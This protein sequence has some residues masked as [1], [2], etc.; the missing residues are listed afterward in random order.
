MLQNLTIA[1]GASLS[2]AYDVGGSSG[3]V[4]GLIFDALFGGLGACSFQVSADGVAWVDLYDFAG[5][6][7]VWNVVPGTAM[8][9]EQD[10]HQILARWRYI[11]IRAGIAAFPVLQVADTII[12]V[13]GGSN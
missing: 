2:N 6:E 7:I 5:N 1:A 11:R 4:I 8:A 13:T 3:N 9:L 12:A 10:E